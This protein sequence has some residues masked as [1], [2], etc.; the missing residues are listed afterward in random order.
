MNN[1][2]MSSKNDIVVTMETM[3]YQIRSSGKYL[4][5]FNHS[6]YVVKTESF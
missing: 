3:T 1:I 5:G 2:P 4:F 6:N